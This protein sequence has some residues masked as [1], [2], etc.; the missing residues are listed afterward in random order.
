MVDDGMSKEEI[1]DAYRT[2]ARYVTQRLRLAAVSPAAREEI[3]TL[4]P[5]IGAEADAMEPAR[6]LVPGA[7]ARRLAQ[8]HSENGQVLVAG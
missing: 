5:G 2:T 8:R 1:A 3:L 7:Q 4:F 6:V